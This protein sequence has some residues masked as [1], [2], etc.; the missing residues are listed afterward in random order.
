MATEYQF[1][2]LFG[3]ITCFKCGAMFR[4]QKSI[5]D[6][7]HNLKLI[8]ERKQVENTRDAEVNKQHHL[9]K[10]FVKKIQWLFKQ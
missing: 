8:Q 7:R 1:D 4:T 5:K 2:S 3:V 9:K 10:W 6:I